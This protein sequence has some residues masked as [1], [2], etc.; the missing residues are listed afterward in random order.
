MKPDHPH[1]WNNMGNALK[2]KGERERERV[3]KEE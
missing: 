1:G 2:D 3:R